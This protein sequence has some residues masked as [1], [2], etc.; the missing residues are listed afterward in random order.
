MKT[1][2]DIVYLTNTPSFYKVN[3]CNEVAKSK[4]LL[5]VF[6][7]YGDEAVNTALKS[8]K[9]YNFDYI[10]LWEGNS[11]KRN[12]FSCFTKLLKL[13]KQINC[14]KIIYEGWFVP[15]YILY[16]F[17]S[18]RAKNCMLCESTI[19]ESNISG[20]RGFIKRAIINRCS[21]A[22]PSG[23]AHKAIFDAMGFKG[24]IHITGGVGIFHKPER[25]IEKDKDSTEKKYLYVGRLIP[26]KNLEFLIERFNENGKPLTIVGKGELESKLKAMA[27]ENISFKG[28][29]ENNK[30][31]EV[32]KTHDVFILPS[33]TE[34]WGLVID[35]AIYWGLP[36]ITSDKVGCSNEMVITP[37]TGV[38]FELDNKDSFNNA[39]N[40]IEN[41]YKLY[42]KNA[43]AF[44]F[45][46]RDRNQIE[47]YF[48]I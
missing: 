27:K 17:I 13:M 41:N 46:E 25:V 40:D 16:S 10:F 14:N 2:Y 18:P 36:I 9:D 47:A 21:T 8:D 6:Y 19:Y 11:A 29:V 28:F 22:L 38:T 42:R 32:Y 33:R 1:H 26:C 30:L 4:S 5:L 20:L 45:D 39:I 37:Q 43:I 24:D 44:D 34:P 31:P 23:I 35:E 7:G 48:K 3:L 15:E 12:K